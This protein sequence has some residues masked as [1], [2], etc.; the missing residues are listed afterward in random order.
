MKVVNLT[1]NPRPL[2]FPAVHQS[3]LIA[4]SLPDPRPAS[5]LLLHRLQFLL[6]PLPQ[7]QHQSLLLPRPQRLQLRPRLWPPRLQLRLPRPPLLQ[8]RQPA[9]SLPPLTAASER[10]TVAAKCGW[11]LSPSETSPKGRRSLWTTA[12]RSGER[13]WSVPWTDRIIHDTHMF[14]ALHLKNL[15]ERLFS[16]S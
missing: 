2:S 10:S 8:P 16:H 3:R 15:W 5:L 4:K 11:S 12:W 7:P 6:L 1:F 9:P 13:I 14:L